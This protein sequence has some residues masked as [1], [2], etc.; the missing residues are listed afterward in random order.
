MSKQM[1][2]LK[3]GNLIFDKKDKNRNKQRNTTYEHYIKSR[4]A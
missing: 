1:L 4:I 2:E 3:K